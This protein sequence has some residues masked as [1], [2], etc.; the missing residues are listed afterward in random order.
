MSPTT[1][2]L[3]VGAGPTGLTAALVLAMNGVPFRIIEKT[4]TNHVGQRGFGIQ[5]RTLEIFHFLRILNDIKERGR[6]IAPVR[7]YKL[8]GGTEPLKTFHLIPPV[9]PTPSV[10]YP[11][12]FGI[13]QENTENILRSHL[14]KYGHDVELETELQ[15]LEQHPDHVTAHLVK[16]IGT[17]E[18]TETITCHWLVGTDGGRG[19]VRKQL[20]L[21]FQGETLPEPVVLGE[22]E[23][24]GID[25]EHWHQWR[26]AD[27][28]VMLRPTEDEGAFAFMIAGKVDHAK[29]VSD[30]EAL[31]Q[32][33]W[34]GME[35][36]D[37]V[38]GAIKSVTEYR[39]NARMVDKFFQDRVF[40]AGDA[41]H[42]HS[43]TGG[44]GLNSSVQ[45]AFNLAWKLALV[46][47]GFAAPAL[48]STYDEERLPVIAHMLRATTNIYHANRVASRALTAE[49][50]SPRDAAWTRSQEMK[51]LSINYRWSSIVIDERSGRLAAEVDKDEDGKPGVDAYGEHSGDGVRAGDRAPDAPGLTP[52]G[53]TA[54]GADPHSLF[55]VFGPAHHTVLLLSLD[56]A[57][58]GP[59][60]AAL[61]DYPEGA[62]RSAVVLPQ[63]AHA[64][65]SVAGA[66]YTFVD[67]EG[68][69]R[70]G[71]GV[72][73]GESLVVIVRPDGVVGGMVRGAEGVRAYFKNI[74][75]A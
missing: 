57:C 24:C 15:S 4:K 43:P 73:P 36:S 54:H 51:Q 21:H 13:G 26:S 41:A 27:N 63:D 2:V 14:E 22:I 25:S 6:S 75:S 59:V 60:L 61:G 39:A 74:F 12:P 1:P 64:S 29:L 55:S 66:D 23:A 32:T 28:V 45:D 19:I 46:C 7:F 40:L 47:K 33:M 3:I 37:I 30:R 16:K 17:E 18:I 67:Q 42:I 52:V 50:G 49:A 70:V 65:G 11:N 48:L 71:Y 20:G 9:D 58:A 44:Q 34:D 56:A 35:R 68:H 62:V 72:A 69:A 10:P 8:P 53:T 38:F 31:L 5:P